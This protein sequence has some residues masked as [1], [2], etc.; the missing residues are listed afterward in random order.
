[1]QRRKL[2]R[3]R[4]WYPKNQ[5]PQKRIKTNP[6]V[7]LQLPRRSLGRV[8]NL[9]LKGVDGSWGTE[10]IIPTDMS[11]A[12]AIFAIN[13]IAPGTGS[14]NRIGRQA[15]MRSIRYT[16]T[17]LVARQGGDD[18]DATRIR[19]AL[20]WDRQP[21]GS[22]PVKSDIFGKTPQ[23]GTEVSSPYDWLRYDNMGRFQILKDDIYLANAKSGAMW[24]LGKSFDM[25]E[26]FDCYVDL[27]NKQT[28]YSGQNSPSTIADI[29]SGA[30]Y[31]VVMRRGAVGDT[32][33]VTLNGTWRL[34][35]TD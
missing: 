5:R 28:T 25:I 29:S 7:V 24:D 1:M 21:G 13:L 19:M 18:V 27:K 14:Y 20:I 2:I 16:G 30:L 12:D 26:N 6:P 11:T 8:D 34:R 31:L 22:L 10:V 3:D 32:Y 35:Y 4:P 15:K 17:F 23:T 9:E 33:T